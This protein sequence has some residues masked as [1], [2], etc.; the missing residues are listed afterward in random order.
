[1]EN[2]Y[3]RFMVKVK[4]DPNPEMKLLVIIKHVFLFTLYFRK[5]Y[6]LIFNS[7]WKEIRLVNNWEEMRIIVSTI[8][9]VIDVKILLI[10]HNTLTSNIQVTLIT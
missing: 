3:L 7:C 4:G 10:S 9:S 8:E 6:F 1:M 5:I 2:T